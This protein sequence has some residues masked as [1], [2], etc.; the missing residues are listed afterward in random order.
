MKYP[1]FYYAK[2][3]DSKNPYYRKA[4]LNKVVTLKDG[5]YRLNYGPWKYPVVMRAVRI[6]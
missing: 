3:E 2:D 1:D 5:S 6:F 4:N